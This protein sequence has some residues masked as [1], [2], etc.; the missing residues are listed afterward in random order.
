[1]MK[2]IIRLLI[3]ALYI[4]IISGV[5]LIPEYYYAF[6]KTNNKISE[7]NEWNINN[8]T[9]VYEVGPGQAY[10][11]PNDVPWETLEPSTIVRIHWSE[12]PYRCKWVITTSASSD[13]PLVVV[14][15]PNGNKLPVITGENATTRSNMYYLNEARSVVKVG[16]YTGTDDADRPSYV[17]LENLDIRSGRLPYG[18]TDRKGNAGT[19]NDNAASVHIEEGERITV[20]GCN[21]HDSGNGLFT[22]YLTK[23]ILISQNHIYNNGIEG[24]SYQ[25]NTYTE[26]LGI[27]YEYNHFGPLRNGCEGNNL[28]DRSAGTVIRYNW[29]ESGN[30]QLDLVN[31]GQEEFFKDPS[32]LDTYV[33]G[34]ILIEPEGAGNGQIIHYG[35]DNNNQISY[36]RG[37]IHLYHNTVISTRNGNTTLLR[38]STDDATADIRNNIIYTSAGSGHLALT[39]GCGIVYLHNNWLPEGYCDTFES[40]KS[41]IRADSGNLKGTDPGFKNYE[42][43]EYQL[44]Q[45]SACIDESAASGADVSGY[46]PTMQYVIHQSGET[47]KVFGKALDIGAFEVSESAATSTPASISMTLTIG[48]KVTAVNGKLME[49]DVPPVLINNRTM[50]PLR[51][52]GEVLGVNFD[53]NQKT[54]TVTCKQGGKEISLI[55]DQPIAGFDTPAIIIDGRTMVP[56]RYISETFGAQV[57]W[58]DSTKSVMVVK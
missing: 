2:K 58:V 30:R 7:I 4:L 6:A 52:I 56:L 48:S 41:D 10:L 1:M 22:T 14:G 19:Y 12:E 11:T 34:N 18:F 13:A 8:F 54:R 33:Y 42:N 5:T 39:N 9:H 27:I 57:T 20:R 45:S 32:Y 51:F 24:S 55:I 40:S 53:W 37:V 44:L 21:L 43:K 47:R 50:V 36:R 49:T 35:G 29:I 25:H 46:E 17:Y 3:I 23:D 28:K 31:T 16:N 26:S 38:L 15:V